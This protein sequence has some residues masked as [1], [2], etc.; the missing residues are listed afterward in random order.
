MNFYSNSQTLPIVINTWSING[1]EKAPD[2]AWESLMKTGNRLDAIEA[3]CGFCEKAQCDGTVG[4]GGSPDESGN[5]TLD[6]MIFDGPTHSLGAVGALKG[7]KNAIGVA[8]AVL[9]FT[10]HSFLAGESATKFAIEMG[11]KQE[12]LATNHSLGMWQKWLANNCQPNYREN[13]VPDPRKA[14]GPYKPKPDFSNETKKKVPDADTVKIENLAKILKI[15]K[16]K[17]Y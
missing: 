7:I 13:V 4:F 14:C 2:Y 17:N 12:S 15:I 6:A 3:G 9:K 1:Y 11:F 8:R 5:T 10:D 16:P